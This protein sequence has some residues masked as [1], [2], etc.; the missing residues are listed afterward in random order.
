MR[1]VA[2]IITM[3]V[4]FAGA[5]CGARSAVSGTKWPR[6]STGTL[7]EA[8]IAQFIKLAP[9]IN[10]ALRASSWTT[11][12]SKVD[13]GPDAWLVR[14]VDGLN[15]PGVDE[16]LKTAGSNWSAMRAVLYRVIPAAQAVFADKVPPETIERMRKD[17]TAAGKQALKRFEENKAAYLLIPSASKELASKHIQELMTIRI[18]GRF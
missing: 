4:V 14:F 9:T 11:P 18:M 1:T 15:V 13:E 17:T 16:S 2:S 8:D 7:T 5:C 10:A 3:F 12:P 6:E